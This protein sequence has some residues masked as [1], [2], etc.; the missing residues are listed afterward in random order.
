MNISDKARRLREQKGMTQDELAKAISR[1]RGKTVSQQNI[2]QFESGSVGQPRYLN[3]LV[4]ALGLTLDEFFRTNVHDAD[5]RE[6]AH[7]MPPPVPLV[8]S[9]QAGEWHE[10]I[11]LNQPGIGE[12]MIPTT[13]P[14]SNTSFALRVQGDSMTTPFGK[15]Y[16]EGMYII[17]DPEQA[18]YNGDLVVAKINGHNEVTFKKL[19][20]EGGKQFLMPLNPQYPPIHDKFRVLGKVIQG[21]F[22]V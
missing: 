21:V 6:I 4:K 12:V 17:V 1:L 19:V 14:H 2:Q 10:A 8:S 3:E 13:K 11:D 5:F 7:N 16:W 22:D 20:I 15:S 9:I 18:A